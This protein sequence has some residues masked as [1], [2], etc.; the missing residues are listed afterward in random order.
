MDKKKTWFLS[1]ESI[2][3]TKPCFR[4]FV[5]CPLSDFS[6]TNHQCRTSF[7]S[8][9]HGGGSKNINSV[10]GRALP[11]NSIVTMKSN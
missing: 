11:Q 10:L 6:L 4:R 8:K 3:K 5:L 1:K 2:D 7:F 9:L